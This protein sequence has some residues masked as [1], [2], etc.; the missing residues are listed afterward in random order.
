M[1]TVS[2]EIYSYTTANISWVSQIKE[3]KPRTNTKYKYTV[4]QYTY[5]FVNILHRTTDMKQ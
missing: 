4:R 5:K 2:K 3:K 1:K